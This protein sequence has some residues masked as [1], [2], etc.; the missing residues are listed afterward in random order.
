[1]KTTL[2]SSVNRLDGYLTGIVAKTVPT[3]AKG[4]MEFVT[5]IG[6][7]AV[8]ISILAAGAV[9]ALVFGSLPLALTF[10]AGAFAATVPGMLK[11]VFHRTRPDTLYVSMRHPHG[12]SFPS[13]HAA[14][15]T[16][17]YGMYAV[18]AAN[19]LQV[20][21]GTIAIVAA[22][23]LV[24]LIGISRIWLGAHYPTDVLGGWVIGAVLLTLVSSFGAL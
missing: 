19:H 10:G 15:S 4:L 16:V 22:A 3:Q 2:S 7:P 11:H 21:G 17:A 12:T 23:V 1:M 24:A 8:T 6:T 9:L 13:G 18:L 20:G 5:S 14:G